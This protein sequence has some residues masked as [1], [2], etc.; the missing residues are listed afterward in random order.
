MNL[1]KLLLASLFAFPLLTST[2]SANSKIDVTTCGA[3]PSGQ[4]D[5]APAIQSCLNSAGPQTAVY[6]P[7]GA[8]KIGSTLTIS[9]NYVTLYSDSPASAQLNFTGCGD[10]VE[11]S[12]N[13]SGIIFNGGIRNLF[14]NGDG[15]CPQTA[16]QVVDSSW[17]S[18][19]DAR[20][21]GF[22]DASGQSIGIETNGREGFNVHNVY[23][24][25]NLPIVIGRNLDTAT[26]LDADHFHFDD[27]YTQA[28]GPNWH[29]T[30]MD[31][32]TVTNTTIDGENA[33]AGGCGIL[34]WLSTAIPASISY[35][36]KISN[37]RHEQMASGCDNDIDIELP[38]SLQ[39]LVIDNVHLQGPFATS[40]TAIKLKNVEG[41]TVRNTTFED[42]P[43]SSAPATFINASD[44]RYVDLENNHVFPYAQSI[45]ATDES[46]SPLVWKSGPYTGK[47]CCYQVNNTGPWLR[48]T[49]SG[50]L[51]QQ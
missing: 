38:I 36:L 42:N 1:V 18:V 12:K 20:I 5:S 24:S 28:N 23:I 16:L 35:D 22:V 32:V 11:F 27:L 15:H 31:G 29:I 43:P 49:D 50:I 6:F 9:N 47:E 40:A 30:V 45:V 19:D 48:T 34:K 44:I 46:G 4:K 3:D 25:A 8:Y 26:Y 7:P 14:L 10:M 37:I 2:V 51:G 17:I 21:S 13:G 41:V 39:S 33:M